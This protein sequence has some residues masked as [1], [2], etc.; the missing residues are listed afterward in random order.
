MFFHE[1]PEF[2]T[3]VALQIVNSGFTFP[4]NTVHYRSDKHV[5]FADVERWATAGL[6]IV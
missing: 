1:K 4:V 5:L 3:E 2:A 6:N